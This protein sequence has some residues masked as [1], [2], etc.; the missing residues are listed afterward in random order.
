M[1]STDEKASMLAAHS[2]QTLTERNMKVVR[3]VLTNEW[4]D[5]AQMVS[6]LLQSPLL[7]PEDIR[8]QCLTR[9]LDDVEEPYY[10]LSA[11]LGVQKL[12]N[13]EETELELLI[14]HLK[15]ALFNDH[16]AVCMRVFI[17]LRRHMKFPRDTDV[18]VK[19]L[20]TKRSPLHDAALSWLVLNVNDKDELKS[21]LGDA[22]EDLVALAEK[23]M[24]E[25]CSHLVQGKPSPVNIEVVDYIPTFDDFEAMM[26]KSDALADFFDDLDTDGDNLLGVED[27]RTFLSDIGKDESADDIIKEM[28]KLEIEDTG[29][30]DRDGFIELMFP[31]FNIQ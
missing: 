6:K 15:A 10:I 8:I 30:I 12:K 18:F 7:I 9:A 5:D 28:S 14:P 21:V 23:K 25:H 20:R 3:N 24:E 22:P 13:I 17:T 31:Q 4:E 2:L 19:I 1:A 11:A 26:E 27:V 29:K 16:G